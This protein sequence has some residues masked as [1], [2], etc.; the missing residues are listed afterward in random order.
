MRGSASLI[1]LI[2]PPRADPRNSA[3]E[4]GPASDGI[5]VSPEYPADVD[6][7]ALLRL[8][9]APEEDG[10]YEV[11]LLLSD[12]ELPNRDELY[13]DDFVAVDTRDLWVPPTDASWSTPRVVFMPFQLSLSFEADTDAIL[14]VVVGDQIVADHPLI[15]RAGVLPDAP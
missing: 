6:V 14:W 11:R 9:F 15:V 8:E 3:L 4:L 5:F 12:V 1:L 2:T 13:E 10:Q 7:G